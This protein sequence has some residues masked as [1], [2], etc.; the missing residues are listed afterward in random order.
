MTARRDDIL[1]WDGKVKPEENCCNVSG[2]HAKI[3]MW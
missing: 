1:A 3:V 2:S